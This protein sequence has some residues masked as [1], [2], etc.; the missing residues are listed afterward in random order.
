M[1]EILNHMVEGV[2]KAIVGDLKT[3]PNHN[4][5]VM[6]MVL[7]AYNRFQEDEKGG[8][9]YLFDINNQDDLKCCVEGGMTAAEIADL[10]DQSKVNMTPLF[11][12]GANYKTPQQIA[13][14]EEVKENMINW[15]E[16][17]LPCVIAYP[18]IEEYQMVY[19]KYVTEYMKENG[20]VP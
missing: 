9:D 4:S 17:V 10:Y 5:Y 3:Y 7:E 8:V 16:D 12:F 1:N 13:T 6:E 2:K 20:L 11:Y 18:Y 19:V 15:L 14:W